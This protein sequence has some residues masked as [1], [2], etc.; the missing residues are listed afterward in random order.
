MCIYINMI[1]SLM[2][3]NVVPARA[4]SLQ[5]IL[6]DGLLARVASW[7]GVKESGYSKAGL[8]VQVPSRWSRAHDPARVHSP[9]KL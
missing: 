4:P 9:L 3:I 1:L 7:A 6:P 8:L 5:P 2:E